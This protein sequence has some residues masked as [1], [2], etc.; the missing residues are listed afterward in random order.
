MTWL[1][2][3][4][5]RPPSALITTD[6]RHQRG[7]PGANR[8]LFAG[9]LAVL[10]AT[11]WAANHFAGLLPAIRDHQ[12]P[13]ASTL[14][15][16]FGIYA[17]GL[18]PGLLIGGRASDALGRQ[19]VAWAGSTAALL[20]TVAML[21]SQ[22]SAVLLVGRVIVGVGVG[23]A[24]SSCT[25]WASDLKGPAGAAVAGAVLT[26]GFAIGPFASGL[27]A[28]AGQSGIRVSFAI[29]AVIVVLATV[30]AVLVAQRA[31]VT[32]SATAPRP[33]WS[34]T[35]MPLRQGSA[36]ALSWAMPLAPWVFASA[37][38]AF[39]TIPS[40]VHTGFAAP[41]VAGIAT[42]IANGVSALTQIV[43]RARRWGPRAGTVG[44]QLAAL[45]YAVIAM[46][47]PTM[48][49][50]LGLSMLVILGCASGL[51]LREGLIDLEAAAPERV[52]GALTGAF[53]TVSYVGFGLPLLLSTV[54][55]ARDSAIIL[56][57]M[58]VLASATAASRAV[59]LRRDSH[60]QN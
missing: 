49:L 60:R 31:A 27:I 19:S 20:G 32:A 24:I 18:L 15:A 38:L 56:A 10:L 4:T 36:W 6:G 25:A 50:G 33:E 42:L 47:P 12:H 28:S 44:A 34:V 2:V 57:V 35:S 29:A 16:V 39:V 48:T 11:G 7:A 59:R 13:G 1:N 43:A 46:A 41:M 30:A 55:S 21:V 3:A 53:Y 54:G 22:H 5:G 40:R 23:L 37:T 9:V 26:A 14:D 45:G 8:A 17:V 52:R 58:A 51:L